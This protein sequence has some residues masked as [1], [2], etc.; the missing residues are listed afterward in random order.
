MSDSNHA[1][2]Q[3]WVAKQTGRLPDRPWYVVEPVKPTAVRP[4]ATSWLTGF[5]QSD[6]VSEGEALAIVA[7]HNEV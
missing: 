7:A 2:N 3:P 5:M 4:D 6:L 1:S